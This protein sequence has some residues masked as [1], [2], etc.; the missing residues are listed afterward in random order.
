MNNEDFIEI[1]KES[2]LTCLKTSERSPQ[3][4]NVLHGAI[5]KDIYER[6]DDTTYT[7]I[8]K[9]FGNGKEAQIKG[10]YVNKD[11]DITIKRGE[12]VVA[13]IAV[14]FVMSNYSQNSNNYF[15][16]MLGETANIRCAKIPYFQVFIVPDV[17]PYYKKGGRLEK[18]EHISEQ[19]IHKYINLSQDNIDLFMHT[20][21][22][23][24]IFIIN[25]SKNNEYNFSSKENFKEYYLNNDFNITLSSLNFVFSNSIIYNNYETFADKI[26]HAILSI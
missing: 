20:P 15:E 23:T 2:F 13:G 4:L 14:K 19:Q 12:D 10:R 16:N 25:I 21:S 22:K 1:L 11:V 7:I 8:S 3:K 18:W 17:L 6:L 9:G 5:A 26:T 24:L